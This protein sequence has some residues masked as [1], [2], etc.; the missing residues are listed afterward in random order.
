MCVVY[1]LRVLIKLIRFLRVNGT[2][3]KLVNGM[4]LGSDKPVLFIWSNLGIVWSVLV[5]ALALVSMYG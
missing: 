3:R 5:N 1:Y 2:F 4:Y